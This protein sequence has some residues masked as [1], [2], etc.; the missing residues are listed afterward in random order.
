[1]PSSVLSR[2]LILSPKVS[3]HRTFK[4]QLFRD[5]KNVYR[6]LQEGDYGF[7][8][9]LYNQASITNEHKPKQ[10]ELL[11]SQFN[12]KKVSNKKST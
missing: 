4:T 11:D 2:K 6:L 7:D 12:S 5:Q 3:F 1:M 8:F 10:K 9:V